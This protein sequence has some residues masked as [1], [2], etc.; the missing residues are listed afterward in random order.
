MLSSVIAPKRVPPSAKLFV[1]K[2]NQ[3]PK[4]PSTSQALTN[5][6]NDVKEIPIE[7]I[8]EPIPMKS[9]KFEEISPLG[10]SPIA[11]TVVFK[12]N[13]QPKV[14]FKPV[15]Q[16]KSIEPTKPT[17]ET[18]K[19]TI[20]TTNNVLKKDPYKKEKNIL[21]SSSTEPIIKTSNPRKAKVN[22]LVITDEVHQLESVVKSSNSRTSTKRK[23][24]SSITLDEP[25]YPKTKSNKS[26]TSSLSNINSN[27]LDLSKLRQ[28]AEE[29]KSPRAKLTISSALTKGQNFETSSSKKNNFNIF[30]RTF[31]N[32]SSFDK[33]KVYVKVGPDGVEGLEFENIDNRAVI[34][35]IMDTFDNL[36]QLKVRDV[37]LS[38]NNLDARYVKYDQIINAL[39]GPSDPT[40]KAKGWKEENSKTMPKNTVSD[41][42][43]CLVFARPTN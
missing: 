35:S 27:G 19:P 40:T 13:L 10:N 33:F 1:P 37:I 41:S 25:D 32:P 9:T 4:L 5:D 39:Y 43:A 29:E 17:I 34:K 21:T 8:T 42:I 14:S 26:G 15:V 24:E 11:K 38:V 16:I 30:P 7:Q 20:E 3:Q 22:E 6:S 28:L 2:G 36:S 31:G 23:I 12:P 18:T